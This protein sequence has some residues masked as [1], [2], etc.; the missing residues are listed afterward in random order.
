MCRGRFLILLTAG[1]AVACCA[2][3]TATAQE[4]YPSRSVRIIV[5]A[6]AAS[7]PDI[8]ARIVADELSKGWG[9]PVVVEDR[10]GGGGIISAQVVAS[11]P[12][13]GYTLLA[14]SASIFTIL[15]VQLEKSPVDVNRDLLPVALI[16]SEGMLFAV[17]PKLG[18]NSLAEFVALAKQRPYQL[19]IGTNPAG[20]LPHLAARLLVKLTDAPVTVVPSSGGTNDAIKEII[21]GRGHAVIDSQPSLRGAIEA[22]ELKVLATMLPRRLPARPDIPAAVETVP[23]LTAIGWQAIAV[24]SG[25]PPAIVAALTDAIRTAMAKPETRARLDQIGSPFDP[26]FGDDVVRFVRRDQELWWPIVKETVAK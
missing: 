10:P 15:P 9:Q 16:G 24:R 22:G 13:D 11:A 1:V 18:V 23:G 21:A 7:S 2:A 19:L 20:S 26:L 3:A 14:A 25:T 4:H 6:P 17:A 12:A 8:R 5:S